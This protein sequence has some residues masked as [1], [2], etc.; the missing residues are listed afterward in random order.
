MAQAF[1][2]PNRYTDTN[3]SHLFFLHATLE[4]T[5]MAINTADT[6]RDTKGD[7]EHPHP[8]HMG[9]APRKSEV[10]RSTALSNLNYLYSRT[11][12]NGHLP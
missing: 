10:R 5:L 4:D 12:A 3:K 6:L 8:F 1:L 7:D 2:T 11:S 9:P